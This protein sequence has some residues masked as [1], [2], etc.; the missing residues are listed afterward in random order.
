MRKSSEPKP[1]KNKKSESNEG[2]KIYND[3]H[4][5]RACPIQGCKSV[6]KCLSNHKRQVHRDIPVGSQFYKKILREARSAKT[7]KPSEQVKRFHS[8]EETKVKKCSLAESEDEVEV[9]TNNTEPSKEEQAIMESA[10]EAYSSNVEDEISVVS[11]FCSGLQSADGGRKDKKLSKQHASQLF[12]I[13]QIIDPSLQFESLFNKALVS[14]TF[15]TQA[16]AKYTADTVKAYLLSLRHFCSY[17]VAEK[18]ESVDVDS[19]L[20]Q[21]L[22]HV[23]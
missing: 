8:E 4:C 15:L 3:Y 6:V 17:V 5:H 13:L 16:E 9:Q 23:V 2:K 10:E 7:W 14:D 19:A 20:V 11:S 18:P 12:R 1:V 22:V 21:S